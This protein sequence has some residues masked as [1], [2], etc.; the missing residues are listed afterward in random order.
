MKYNEDL[1]IELN[2]LVGNSEITDR[3]VLNE[4]MYKEPRLINTD[5]V[6]RVGGNILRPDSNF[7]KIQS[8]ITTSTSSW[9]VDDNLK[10]N[11]PSIK[12]ADAELN[13][14]TAF[15]TKVKTQITNAFFTLESLLN[16][17]IIAPN[18]KQM[19]ATFFRRHLMKF[20]DVLLCSM[21]DSIAK[22]S[23][24]KVSTPESTFDGSKVHDLFRIKED[25]IG[26]RSQYAILASPKT[27]YAAI[28]IEEAE[29]KRTKG[30]YKRL[31]TFSTQGLNVGTLSRANTLVE[32]AYLYNNS[33]GIHLN[34]AL[35]DG[36]I[37]LV[38]KKAF[39]FRNYLI[40]NPVPME[41]KIMASG[42]AGVT[43]IGYK[44]AFAL[45]PRGFS[46]KTEGFANETRV[47]PT[48]YKAAAMFSN[49]YEPK[50]SSVLVY[51]FK[52]G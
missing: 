13:E 17:N 44:N 29:H 22:I 18:T 3:E 21:L 46:H 1:K 35:T 26:E 34:S 49:V 33:T 51:E 7:S 25:M 5:I 31:I 45:H 32:P 43:V 47:T 2:K 48:E 14:E 12:G 28:D 42:G 40:K 6:E 38:Q 36:H 23:T 39:L 11:T 30:V 8:I 15:N 4:E 19:V 9:G 41:T 27:I 20:Y 52:I 24:I 37:Y 50:H 10:F 16:D